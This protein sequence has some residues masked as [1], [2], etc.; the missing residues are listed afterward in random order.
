ME[1][2]LVIEGLIANALVGVNAIT[3]FGIAFCPLG[4]CSNK[5]FKIALNV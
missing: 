5:E 1:L 4:I 3:D 2:E